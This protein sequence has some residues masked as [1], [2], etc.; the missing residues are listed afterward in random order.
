ML[1]KYTF[2]TCRV[3]L[4]GDISLIFN[5]LMGVSHSENLSCCLIALREMNERQT[6]TIDP[7]TKYIRK[8]LYFL[9]AFWVLYAFIEAIVFI[10][11]FDLVTIST[12]MQ[13]SIMFSLL[14]IYLIVLSCILIRNLNEFILNGDNT[15][16]AECRTIKITLIIFCIGFVLQVIKN[17]ASLIV[18]KYSNLKVV[19][20]LTNP[21]INL[22]QL[23]CYI[24]QDV[25]PQLAIMFIHRKN[26][27]E[28]T[29]K[30]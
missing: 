13:L 22:I 15:F 8:F 2:N 3:F 9:L 4:I 24:I 10:T 5:F 1:F 6:S 12:F 30:Q 7:Y 16:K 23:V 19:D 18:I 26:F 25:V 27:Q 29:A 11:E 17:L 14:T 28:V 21:K 20:M